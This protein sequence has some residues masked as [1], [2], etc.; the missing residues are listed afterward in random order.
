M[1]S[2]IEGQPDE[3][4]PLLFKLDLGPQRQGSAASNLV[5]RDSK[6]WLIVP[7]LIGLNIQKKQNAHPS[8]K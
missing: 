8:T 4:L 7:G 2:N 3:G 5:E 1:C 6:T